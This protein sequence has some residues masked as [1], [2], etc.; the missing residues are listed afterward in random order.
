MLRPN[1]PDSYLAWPNLLLVLNCLYN[2]HPLRTKEG[3]SSATS[4]M[5]CVS[6][7]HVCL[8]PPTLF[9]I[10]LRVTGSGSPPSSRRTYRC[11]CSERN[12]GPHRRSSLSKAE[13]RT[14]SFRLGCDFTRV[15]AHHIISIFIV[16]RISRLHIGAQVSQ[17]SKVHIL[18]A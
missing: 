15:M 5:M 17:V 2:Q 3:Q 18:A 13:L 6:L 9:L 16:S 7:S 14:P 10:P 4:G 8:Q 12:R 1:E 11:S